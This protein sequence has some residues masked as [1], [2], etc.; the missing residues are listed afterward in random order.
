[1]Q[2]L[3][4]HHIASVQFHV[5]EGDKFSII[6]LPV[7]ECDLRHFLHQCVDK[8]FPKKEI[9][10]LTSWFGCLIGALAFAH[11]KQVKHE[12]IKPSN[13]LIKEHQPYLAD[14]GSAKDFSGLESSTTLDTLTFGTLVYWAPEPHP[15]GR[16]AD[17]FSLGCVFSEMLTVRHERSLGDFQAFRH[18][19][20]RD[21]AYAFKENLE[22]VMDWLHDLVPRRDSVGNL[23]KEQTYKMLEL[24]PLQRK[25]AKDIKRNL[26][27]EGDT[28][29]CSTCF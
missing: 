24:D 17:V 3:H 6:M 26:R 12:D 10:H 22:K 1:M 19:P 7:A 13:I 28:V 11:S 4:H 23:L 20:H 2:R 15:R 27:L 21:N 16:A 14:F 25:E 9:T 29:F 8:R 18:I 5:F